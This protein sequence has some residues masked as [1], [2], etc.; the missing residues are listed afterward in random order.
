MFFLAKVAVL[1]AACKAT[2]AVSVT[3]YKY[4]TSDGPLGVSDGGVY[5][6]L[7]FGFAPTARRMTPST[8]STV[9]ALA[10]RA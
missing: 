10:A 4:D 5:R 3:E 7:G 8:A 6:E 2:A 1:L 9:L